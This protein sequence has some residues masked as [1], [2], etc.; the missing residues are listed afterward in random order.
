MT[1]RCCGIIAPRPVI[2]EPHH[3][4]HGQRALEWLG[5]VQVCTYTPV[6]SRKC[7][8][9]AVQGPVYG[10]CVRERRRV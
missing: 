10:P 6:Q 1:P 2:Q 5:S 7:L 3:Q 4:R 9:S 8:P